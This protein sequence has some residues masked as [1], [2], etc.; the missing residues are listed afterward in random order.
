MNYDLF[1]VIHGLAHHSD[2]LDQA[3]IFITKKA[4]LVYALVLL[5][6]W[7]LGNHNFKKHI[8]FSGVTGIVALI[9]NF[10]ITLFYYEERPFVAHK[11]DTLIPHSADASF[12]SDHTTG[13]LA[14]SLA[15]RSRHKKLG[16]ILLVFGL[17][18]GISRIWVGH[19]YPFDVLGSLIVSIVVVF[20]MNRL[21]TFFDS[22]ID[23]IVSFY[24]TLIGNILK[25]KTKDQ[26]DHFSND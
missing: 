3:M 9:V 22:P 4:I 24:E 20:M 7:L 26:N 15:I 12:P 2:V 6:C 1:Q 13:A 16:N 10:A 23:R 8:F 5:I 17:L 25:K 21:W 18:T 14:L 19:H 11:V